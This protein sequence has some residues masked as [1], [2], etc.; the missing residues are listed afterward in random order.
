MAVGG[1]GFSGRESPKGARV[2]IELTELSRHQPSAFA[3]DIRVDSDD[4]IGLRE[5]QRP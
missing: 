4:P 3:C 1:C 5:E 2:T